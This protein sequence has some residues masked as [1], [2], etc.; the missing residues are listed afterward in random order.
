MKKEYIIGGVIG[1]VF[2]IAIVICIFTGKKETKKV[3]FI[4][5]IAK[6][7]NLDENGNVIEADDKIKLEGEDKTKIEEYANQIKDSA[8]NER[9]S[10]II[11]ADYNIRINEHVSLKIKSDI[12]EYVYYVDDTKEGSEKEIVTRAPEG[13][14][15]WI[16]N[17]VNK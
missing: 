7:S 10:M 4:P 6:I 11:F 17:H 2:I 3:D 13:F 8:Q 12:K 15:E 5:T 16:M 9:Y 1:I 14:I